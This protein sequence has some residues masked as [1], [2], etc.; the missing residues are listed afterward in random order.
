MIDGAFSDGT[1]FRCGDLIHRL[2]NRFYGDRNIIMFTM[3]RYDHKGIKNNTIIP[4]ANYTPKIYGVD[5]CI[6]VQLSFPKGRRI[7]N[8]SN[9]ELQILR[10]KLISIITHEITHKIQYRKRRN[11][12]SN[13]SYRVNLTFVN[14]NIKKMIEYLTECDEVDAHA[15]ETIANYRYGT[16]TRED[17]RDINNIKWD[18]CEAVYLYNKFIRYTDDRIWRKF[19]KKVYKYAEF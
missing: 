15:F 8:L 19:I 5:E 13:S 10:V 17:L 4:A 9:E 11:R 18:K 16:L 2:N 3:G 6:E 12:P 7:I 1:T 14:K